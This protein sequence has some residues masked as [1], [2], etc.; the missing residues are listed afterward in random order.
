VQKGIARFLQ[1]VYFYQEYGVHVMML[2]LR[3]CILELDTINDIIWYRKAMTLVGKCNYN[4]IIFINIT[5]IIHSFIH[6]FIHS[7]I[8]Q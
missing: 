7:F 6:L 2:L 4:I 5:V 1:V 3:L 8:Y